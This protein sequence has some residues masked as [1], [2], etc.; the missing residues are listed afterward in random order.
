MGRTI[1]T[2]RRQVLAGASAALAAPFFV[3]TASAQEYPARSVKVIIPYPAGGGADT[4]G[5]IYFA[6]LSEVMGQ[7][8]VIDNRGGAGGTIAAAAAAKADPDGYTI[9]YDATAF[10]VNSALYPRLPFDYAKDFQSVF[11]AALVPNILVVTP[12]V[13]AKTVADVIAL[14]KAAPDGL[15]FASSGNGTMQHLAMEMFR[16]TTGVKINHIPYRGGGPALNDVIGGQVKFMFANG[17]GVLGH[18][19]AGVVKPIAHT[20]KGRLGTLPDLPSVGDTLSGYEAYEWNGLF[21][22]TGTPAAII[23]KLNAGMNAMHK[24][25]EVAEKL[26]KLNVE[27]RTNTP[28]ECR[29]FVAAEMAKWSRVVKEANIKLG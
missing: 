9:M 18:V 24:Q 17:A 21:V 13:P 22:P 26:T 14:A 12:S 4:I 23:A 7:Q 11:L 28:E 19:Q 20:G 25:A 15:D 27:Y 1:R 3:R 16:H 5:R 6:K 8:F 10:S 2:T 29:A